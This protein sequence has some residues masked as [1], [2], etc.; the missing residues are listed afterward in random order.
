MVA[1]RSSST[2]FFMV[3]AGCDRSRVLPGSAATARC[4]STIAI[5]D[6]LEVVPDHRQRARIELALALGQRL[7]ELAQPP[8]H[9]A[10][11]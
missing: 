10:G 8:R 7:L 4:A 5:V 9:N 11:C 1:E 3:A 2:F 6:D